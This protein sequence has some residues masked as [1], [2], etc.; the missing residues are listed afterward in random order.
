MNGE[1]EDNPQSSPKPIGAAAVPERSMIA[2]PEVDRRR[3]ILTTLQA[4]PIITTLGVTAGKAQ[5]APKASAGASGNSSIKATK[6][7]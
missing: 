2:A 1:T 7:K 4:A 3:I 6:V 5:A